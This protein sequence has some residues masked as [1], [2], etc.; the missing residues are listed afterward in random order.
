MGLKLEGVTSGNG[1]EADASNN[2][3][4]ITPGHDAGGVERGGG[5]AA[6]GDVAILS[7]NDAGTITVARAVLSPETD[8]DFRLRVAHDNILDQESFNYTAQ[9]TGKHTFTFTTMA[10]TIGASGILTNSG[11]VTTTGIGLN[12]GTHAMFPVGGTQ[13]TV[14]ETS[15]AFSAQPTSNVVVDFGL[16]QR[17]VTAAFAPLDGVYFRL[18][19][20]GLMGVVNTGGV[21]VTTA[22][23]PLALG[24]GTYVYANNAVN[25]YLIQVNNV[26]TTFWIHNPG[27]HWIPGQISSVALELPARAR[28]RCGWC[29]VASPVL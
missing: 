10:A 22:V 28:R 24:A 15:V 11:A 21:E 12:F 17:G 8:E 7:E 9:N 20:A 6:A 1:V 16:F 14:C 13:T 23:F 18:S 29:R 19:S 26:S 27:W 5:A 2:M 4:V 3:R 25:R